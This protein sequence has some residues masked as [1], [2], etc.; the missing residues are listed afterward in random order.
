MTKEKVKVKGGARDDSEGND[1][2]KKDK[3]RAGGAWVRKMGRG[4][5]GEAVEDDEVREEETK[6]G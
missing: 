4:R 6:R 2:T 3:K 1:G 5:A